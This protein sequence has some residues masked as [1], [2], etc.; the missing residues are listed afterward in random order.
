[1]RNKNICRL[2]AL[3]NNIVFR[4]MMNQSFCLLLI[5]SLL[6]NSCSVYQDKTIKVE[7]EINLE[8]P[9]I[10]EIKKDETSEKSKDKSLG[11]FW[12]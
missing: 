12:E 9:K 1:M 5:I 11:Y 4:K 2:R 3:Q 8:F 6:L 10:S 7:K